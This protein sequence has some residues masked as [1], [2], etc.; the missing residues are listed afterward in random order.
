MPSR[1]ALAASLLGAACLAAP[2]LGQGQVNRCTAPDGSAIYTDRRCAD[3]GATERTS[4]GRGAAGQRIA[5]RGGCPRNVHDLIHE[6]HAAFDSA[7]VNRLAAVYHWPGT[8]TRT[9]YQLM[10]RL[11]GIVGAPALDIVALRPAQPVTVIERPGGSG[12]FA[13]TLPAAT[14]AHTGPPAPTRAPVALRVRQSVGG[15]A[16]PRQTV[17]T[18]RRNLGCWWVSL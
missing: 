13:S 18:L 4:P 9:G 11:E 14:R 8:S 16:A 7:D 10:T 15:G 12:P 1:A 17:F 2:V 5:Y 6:M 3:L